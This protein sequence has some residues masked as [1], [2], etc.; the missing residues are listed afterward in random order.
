M[1]SHQIT[2]DQAAEHSDPS[3]PIHISSE[4]LPDSTT[5]IPVIA[6]GLHLLKNFLEGNHSCVSGSFHL[7]T[8]PLPSYLSLYQVAISCCVSEYAIVCITGVT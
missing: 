5:E 8:L 1:S 7:V 3:C 4:P 6:E 2:T